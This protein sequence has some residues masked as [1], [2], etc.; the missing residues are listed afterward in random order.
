MSPDPL[1]ERDLRN[2]ESILDRIIEQDAHEAAAGEPADAIGMGKVVRQRRRWPYAVAAAALAAAVGTAGWILAGRSG[3][4]AE[5]FTPPTPT[6]T[7]TA[8]PSP[9]PVE[10][11][12]PAP[13]PTAEF[14]RTPTARPSA[15][16]TASPSPTSR[17]TASTSARTSTASG[18]TAGGTSAGGTTAPAPVPSHQI[19]PPTVRIVRAVIDGENVVITYE[20]CAGSGPA[21]TFGPNVWV[22]DAPDR[23]SYG[24][25]SQFAAG[26][27]RVA[28][29]SA[30]KG[31]DP[32]R[33]EVMVRFAYPVDSPEARA[34]FNA[35]Y[36]A[37]FRA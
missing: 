35:E 9:V 2:P 14:T 19:R 33:G 22:Y 6:V 37:E 3:V 21:Q 10:S 15:S 16:P 24:S 4:T 30:P 5:P 1:R 36:S 27:C 32:V 8:T 23:V 31:P 17:T 34:G 25:Y 28:T 20:T 29:T 7:A 26:E 18:A 12:L 11:E 13:S